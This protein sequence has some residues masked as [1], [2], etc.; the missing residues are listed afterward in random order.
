[1][2]DRRPAALLVVSGGAGE[3]FARLNALEGIARSLLMGVI[4]LLALE[5][6]GSKELVTH[7]YLFASILTLT[8]TLNFATLERLLQRRWVVTLGAGCTLIAMLILLFGEGMIMALGIGLQQASASLFSVCLSLYIMDYIGKKDLIYTETRRMLYAGV[9][10][11]VGPILGLWLWEGIAGWAPF[12]LSL[13]GA[14]A[15]LSY[16]WYLRLGHG[17][18]IQRAKS[19]PASVF[20]VIPRYFGQRA[21]RIAYWI[22]LSR[23]IFWVTL[24]VYGPIYVVEAGLPNWIAGGLLS[25]ASAL[26]LVSPLIRRLASRIGTRRVILFAL[27]LTGL[28]MAMLYVLGEARPIG[29]LFWIT[30]ALG[31]VTLDVLGNIPFMRMVKPRERTEMTMIFSTWREGSQ[32]LTPLLVSTMLLFAPFE[33]FYLLLALLLSGA[34][35]MATFL[36]RRL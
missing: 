29:L 32:L 5:A 34:G 12:V 36:P 18:G 35:I 17:Q 3:S 26:L 25:L 16:F 10:W 6:L 27:M 30:G 24:F 11:M 31:G 2:F 13:F 7:A 20:K 23:A 22:T 28:S 33:T 19:H 1:M 14:G 8:I 9:V 15:M 4:P 21:L